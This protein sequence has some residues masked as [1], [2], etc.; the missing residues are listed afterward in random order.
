MFHVTEKL[1]LS[2]CLL[3]SNCISDLFSPAT[4]MFKFSEYYSEFLHGNCN[5]IVKYWLCARCWWHLHLHFNGVL[6][7][8]RNIQGWRSQRTFAS[9]DFWRNCQWLV[10]AHLLHFFTMPPVACRRMQFSTWNR[11]LDIKLL[12]K[13]TEIAFG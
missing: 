7:W 12:T 2:S 11:E 9:E 3:K 4:I 8:S 5:V 13:I 1:F 10:F 6:S